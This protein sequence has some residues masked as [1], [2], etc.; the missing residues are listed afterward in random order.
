MGREIIK[1]IPQME[2]VFMSHRREEHDELELLQFIT[3]ES[4]QARFNDRMTIL[5]CIITSSYRH[6]VSREKLVEKAIICGANVN[7]L[8]TNN[9]ITPMFLA[10]HSGYIGVVRVLLN[11][12]AHII[13]LGVSS[14]WIAIECDHVD[15][16]MLLAEVSVLG[17]STE[18]HKYQRILGPFLRGRAACV[19][20]TTALLG[21]LAK[22]KGRGAYED[23]NVFRVIAQVVYAT[24]AL[25]NW[26]P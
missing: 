16:A 6:A 4:V 21:A 11:Y 10:T 26:V 19:A 23:R 17:D 25:E 14:L 18:H 7:A 20:S 24:R 9:H 22:R 1:N 2:G 3:E 12:G 8:M 5:H 15:L 13:H